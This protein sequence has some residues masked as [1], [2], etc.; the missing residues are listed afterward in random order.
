MTKAERI[1]ITTR[2][3]CRHHI[4]VWGYITNTDGSAAGYGNL[5]CMDDEHI[6]TRTLNAVQKMLDRDRRFADR[7]MKEGLIT[8]EKYELRTQ[9]F[10]MVQTTINNGRRH[11]EEIKRW[12]NDD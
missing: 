1:Y 2:A 8:P 3:E 11:I 12:I 9:I 10:N 5:I 7:L 6:C 4:E